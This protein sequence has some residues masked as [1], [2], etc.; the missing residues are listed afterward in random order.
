[1]S[2]ALV[3]CCDG[4]W[5]E[6]DELRKGVAAPT[7]VAKVALGV[8]AGPGTGQLL[9]YETGVGTSP[10]ERLVGGAFGF[11]L[12]RNVRNAYSWI[13]ENYD[14]GD[15]ENPADDIYLFGFSRG[16]YTARS[17]A[18]LIRN[19]G[20]LQ[21]DH[22][23]R[24][25]EAFAFYRDRTNATHPSAVS[26]QIFRQ[27]Y[28]WADDTIH[29]I[30]VW[31]TVGALGIPDKLPGWD[32][33]SKLWPGWEE[34]W[35]FHDTQ[36][37]SHVRHA[38]HAV[39]VDEKREPYKPTLWTAF[40]PAKQTLEQVWFAGVHSEVGGGTADHTLSDIALLWM[41]AQ[42]KQYGLKFR[43]GLLDAGRSDG[44]L[45]PQGA[46]GTVTP[47]YAGPLDD[48]YR[49]VWTMLHPYHRLSQ[50]HMGDA[51]QQ[52]VSS[53]AK[54]RLEERVGGYDPAGLRDYLAKG[55]TDVT[56][57]TPPGTASPGTT[58]PEAGS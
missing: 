32:A 29:F 8:I 19:C 2:K 45:D 7:N 13:A 5:N 6:P 26:S 14:P 10:D 46:T 34:D 39:S 53:S 43:P 9:H 55:I 4:T 11:G 54:R 15:A 36:L 49:G 56:E 3:V 50:P 22:V 35:G 47:N 18:G 41:V 24:V 48:S 25:D 30:G 44:V 23:D 1:M 16:A 38:C 58:P 33:V 40:D 51:P 42:A 17:V 52:T 21:K 28:A 37:S 27:E 12:S 31:D 20:I 57:T